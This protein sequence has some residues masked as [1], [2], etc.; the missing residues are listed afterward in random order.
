MKKYLGITGFLI[1]FI[2][3]AIAVAYKYLYDINLEALFEI[4]L[5]T[6]ISTMT[7]SNE[8]NKEKPKKWLISLISILSIIAI[9][10]LLLVY[11]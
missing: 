5:F 4:S 8:M 2:G 1:G 6:W 10:C 3:I 9:T 7:I 11:S